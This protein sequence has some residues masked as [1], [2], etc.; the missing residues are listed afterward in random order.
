ML[1]L[2]PETKATVSDQLTKSNTLGRVSCCYFLANFQ[3]EW[4]HLSTPGLW[5]SHGGSSLRCCLHKGSSRQRSVCCS[6]CVAPLRCDAASP[7]TH[8]AWGCF[9]RNFSLPPSLPP[10]YYL[11]LWFF[12]SAQLHVHFLL[13][14]S[15]PN[16]IAH[17]WRINWVS[18]C[19]GHPDWEALRSP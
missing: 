9:T 16:F 7:Q 5:G 19:E 10:A 8:F 12:S 2:C 15:V 13:A 17:Q 1:T 14:P 6:R 4:Q 11:C 18:V 3:G